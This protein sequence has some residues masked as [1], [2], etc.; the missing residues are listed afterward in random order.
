MFDKIYLIDFKRSLRDRQ[1]DRQ[2]TSGYYWNPSAGRGDV[3]F[4][5]GRNSRMDQYGSRVSFRLQFPDSRSWWC[6]PHGD[7]KLTP[8]VAQLPHQRGFLAGWTMGTMM[9]SSL[10]RDIHATYHDAL[11]RA[12]SYA[13]ESAMAAQEEWADSTIREYEELDLFAA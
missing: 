13:C 7:A 10:E 3:G 5:L 2:F 8:I 1:K 9:A 11:A 4:Y 6:D 12:T